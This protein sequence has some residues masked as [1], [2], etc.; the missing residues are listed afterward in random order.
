MKHLLLFILSLIPLCAS[1]QEDPVV[2]TIGGEPVTRSEFEYN[3]NKNNTDAVV[4]KKSVAEYV[5]MFAVYKMKVRAALDARMDTIGSY[6]REFHQYRDQQIRPLLVNDSMV[7]VECRKYY[8]DMKQTMGGKQLL[9]PAHI[10]VL[11]RQKATA[12]EQSAAKARIDSIY[13]V[14][15]NGG[16]WNELARTCSDDKQTAVNGGELPWVGP[17]QLLKEFEDVAYSLNVG[18]VSAPFLSTVGYHIVKMADRKD[19]EPFDTL[20]A[21]IHRFIEN[22]GVRMQLSQQIVD[23]L[24]RETRGGMTV[25]EILDRETE[26]LCAQD[27]D[28][29]YLVQEYHDGLLYYDIC[30]NGIW[31]PAKT[32]TL[33]LEKYFKQNKKK[34]AWNKPHFYGMLYY[35]KKATDV[36]AVKKA[37]RG[38]GEDRWIATLREKFNKDSVMVKMDRRLFAQGDN[39]VADK[40]VFKVK[41]Q[42]AKTPAG[43]PHTGYMGRMLKKGPAK[44]TDVSQKVIQDLQD[45]RMNEWVE[46]LRRKYPVVV[47]EDI[48]NTVNNH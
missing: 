38:I 33:A 47:F 18:Q 45:E 42:E 20:H 29:K 17:G 40:L 32:D 26:R 30:N 5:D 24:S 15:T 34:Y 8:A 25:D 37:V 2:M 12:A 31:E 7:D 13:N 36:N 1:A 43:Y 4:D 6:L 9:K 11:L 10:F 27:R 22:R 16:D 19:L 21:Q 23:S 46:T 48:L 44:W 28:L 14:L 3:Y 41:G 35:C 39:K